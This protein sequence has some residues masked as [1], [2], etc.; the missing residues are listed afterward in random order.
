LLIIV[1]IPPKCCCSCSNKDRSFL[2]KPIENLVF[3]YHPNLYKLVLN[4]DVKNE[5]SPSIKPVTNQGFILVLLLLKVDK[6]KVFNF[7]CLERILI[8]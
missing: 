7:N 6:D 5:P 3:K 8:R 4:F 2:P 1:P